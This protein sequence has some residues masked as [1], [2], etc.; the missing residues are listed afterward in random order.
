[1]STAATPKGGVR[2][3]AAYEIVDDCRHDLA[4]WTDWEATSG[5]EDV[6]W[7]VRARAPAG[8][9][10]GLALLFLA[11]ALRIRHQASEKILQR[12]GGSERRLRN[13]LMKP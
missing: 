11:W 3:G 8:L 7:V 10:L 9:G 12:L 6:L 5:A 13:A 1:M 4:A 2:A